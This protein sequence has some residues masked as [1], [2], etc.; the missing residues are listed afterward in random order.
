MI[1][2]ALTVAAAT[3]LL[4]LGA[5]AGDDAS[6][7]A[8]N[9]APTV[10]GGPDRTSAVGQPVT[11]QAEGSDPDGNALQF[12]WQLSIAPNFSAARLATTAGPETVVVPDLEGVYV[13]VLW[14]FD[15]ELQSAPDL[16]VLRVGDVGGGTEVS[17][18][19]G[20]DRTVSVQVPAALDGTGSYDPAGLPL[21]FAWTLAPPAGSAATLEGAGTATPTFVPDVAGAYVATLTVTAIGGGTATDSVTLTAA[22]LPPAADPG[23]DRDVYVGTAVPLVANAAD[24][25]GEPISYL[26]TLESRPEGSAAA[27]DG[28]ALAEA[29]LV[30]DVPGWYLVS[31]VV[32][33]PSGT[34]APKTFTVR[35]TPALA[36]LTHRVLDA[37]YA[38]ATDRLVMVDGDPSALY[39]LD[40]VTGTEA[41][42]FLPLPPTSVS[43]SPD[44]ARAAVGHDAYVSIVDLAAAQLEKTIP[45]P[46][47]IGEVV[48][49]TGGWL[50]AFDA[51]YYAEGPWAV[52]VATGGV[53]AASNYI[54]REAANVRLHPS[55][56]RMYG[57]DRGSSPDDLIRYEISGATL[58]GTDSRYH[59]DY[60][61]CGDLWLSEDGARI[62]TACGN[63][64]RSTAL[65]S[66]D[67]TY[68]GRLAAPEGR[69]LWVT[70]STEAGQVVAVPGGGWNA[71]G[72]EDTLL[73]VY[74]D[75]FLAPAGTVAVSP[76][77]FPV[78]VFPGHARFVFFSA[79]GTR[80]F[81]VVQADPASAVV[82]DFAVMSF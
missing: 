1:R 66:T 44:G 71:T 55:G 28:G 69:L 33:D 77:I 30:P 7:P 81:A 75:E 78:G 76:F 16:V 34:A 3:A 27:I 36:R 51:S 29:S 24:P 9:R 80:R 54:W 57:A 49:A 15:G 35:A 61:M 72:D 67:I 47:T 40:P 14:A 52:E 59:G 53:T 11:L 73:R 65:A 17:A 62:F 60:A 43:V 39:V 68:G 12:Q 58:T 42:V 13:V 18:Y 22:N 26:W 38:P 8:P 64:F 74:D 20:P 56:A 79:D 19:A 10:N 41:R 2:N 45:I 48:L 32:S 5:C 50:Y 82:L 25:D 37:E 31:L 63:T 70:H 21:S 6:P 23:G 46:A 4:V